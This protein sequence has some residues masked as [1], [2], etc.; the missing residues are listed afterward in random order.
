MLCAG[1]AVLILTEAAGEE[2]ERVTARSETSGVTQ[3][4]ADLKEPAAALPE[5][6]HLDKSPPRETKGLELVR[7]GWT[8]KC[9]ECHKTVK[10]QW[11]RESP[12]VEHDEIILRHGNNRFCL[13]C[14]NERSITDF[15]D[16]DGSIIPESEV[17]QLCA[18]CHG[19]KYR[20]WKA[21]VHGRP[22]GYWDPE[23]GPS[24]R[25]RCIQCHD[26]HAPTYHSQKPLAPPTYPAR[27]AGSVD[28]NDGKDGASHD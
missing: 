26:P 17:V 6:T 24:R 11:H 21:G 25:L 8:Y 3:S 18:K 20:D 19:P 10:T 5:D 13:N 1:F 9:M 7:L 15:V 14:H 2:E 16:Y 12:R 23:Q 27:A 4:E 22:N 28:G